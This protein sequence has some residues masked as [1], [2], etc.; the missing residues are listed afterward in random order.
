MDT[1]NLPELTN[2]DKAVFAAAGAVL[3]GAVVYF[4]YKQPQQ[5]VAA[6]QTS[7]PNYEPP[8]ST[9]P[10]VKPAA[11]TTLPPPQKTAAQIMEEQYLAQQR[12][13]AANM[14]VDEPKTK[15]E[16]AKASAKQTVTA[17]QTWTQGVTWKPGTDVTVAPTGTVTVTPGGTVVVTNPP[18]PSG[19]G[20]GRFEG[21]NAGLGFLGVIPTASKKVIPRASSTV[22]KQHR[23]KAHVPPPRMKGLAGIHLGTWSEKRL[24]TKYRAMADLSGAD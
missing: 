13:V 15:G 23:A 22:H 10:P 24:N 8:P 21:L 9:P 16:A 14:A 20:P 4:Y 3:V 7:L 5:V 12:V 11:P 18:K 1:H 2:R 17:Q 19:G 6:N